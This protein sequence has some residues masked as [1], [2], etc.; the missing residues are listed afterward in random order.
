MGSG[1]I[2]IYSL[3]STSL[4]FL[5][6]L[7]LYIHPLLTNKRKEFSKPSLPPLLG[8]RFFSSSSTTLLSTVTFWNWFFDQRSISDKFC[9]VILMR[10]LSLLGNMANSIY[11]RRS[12]SL[13]IGRVTYGMA[14]E[15]YLNP[16]MTPTFEERILQSNT[17]WYNITHW[18]I[19]VLHLFSDVEERRRW[20]HLIHFDNI[21]LILHHH[22]SFGTFHKFSI[23]DIKLIPENWG[24]LWFLWK[25]QLDV[26]KWEFAILF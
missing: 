20:P 18:I 9:A 4:K 3:S 15:E 26:T 25:F 1:W 10:K 22:S 14:I 23:E 6:I 19:G 24:V 5:Q 7:P 13:G 16:G 21:C 11:S 8:T 12:V 17:N 2:S